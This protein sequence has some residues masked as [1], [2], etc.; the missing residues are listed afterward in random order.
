M[1]T[2]A[3]GTGTKTPAKSGQTHRSD[4]PRWFTNLLKYLLRT[5][6]HFIFS[7][8]MMLLEFRG[9][10]SGKLYS[11]PVSYMREGD[12]VTAF[13]DSPWQRNL[14]GGAPVTVYLKGKAVEGYC[15]VIDDGDAVSEGLT[16]FLLQNRWVAGFYGVSFDVDGQPILEEVERGSQQH[17]MLRIQLSPT[18]RVSL[19]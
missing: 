3:S 7:K 18:T 11:T 16:H 17:V 6:S 4:P 5:P 2:I 9:R 12:V 14:L 19:M 10:K 15:E 8:S 1:A 13:T